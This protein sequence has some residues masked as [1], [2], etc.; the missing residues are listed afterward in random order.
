MAENSKREMSVAARAAIECGLL[1]R[2]LS[3]AADGEP[4]IVLELNRRF[5]ERDK[6]KV[7]LDA[8]VGSP[9]LALISP[10]AVRDNNPL[11]LGGEDTPGRDST[12]V[13]KFKLKKIAPWNILW[14]HTDAYAPTS[15][16]PKEMLTDTNGIWYRLNKKE[17]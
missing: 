17:D 4:S 3:N 5:A 1:P 7:Y 8:I 9:L 10:H 6:S 2:S 14:N 12:R 11:G 13:R 15:P 16:L